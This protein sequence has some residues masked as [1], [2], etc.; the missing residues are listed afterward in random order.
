MPTYV[1]FLRAINLG[2]T[3]KFAKADIVEATEAAGGTDVLTHINTG[4]VRLTSRLRSRE[5][6]EAALEAAYAAHTGF[7]VPT[8][9]FTT[10]AADSDISSSYNAQANAY[11]TKP[12]NLDDY[13]RVVIE[14]HNFF[15]HTVALPNQ[16]TEQAPDQASERA[17]DDPAT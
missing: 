10:S 12:I 15:G 4:N 1:A 5:K 7:D 13:E 2:P 11:V 17:S 9:V 8:I 16:A 6:V 3:R 14:I